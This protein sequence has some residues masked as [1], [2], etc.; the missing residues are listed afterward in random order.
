[1][2]K[3][4]A[5]TTLASLSLALFAS[6]ETVLS[7]MQEKEI[8]PNQEEAAKISMDQTNTIKPRTQNDIYNTEAIN[9][10]VQ[11]PL[12]AVKDVYNGLEYFYLQDGQGSFYISFEDLTDGQNYV[13]FVDSKTDK[14]ISVMESDFVFTSEFE[15]QFS[16]E[17]WIKEDNEVG[18]KLL[19]RMYTQM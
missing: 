16:S 3:K 14:L 4:F 18:R 7:P 2:F 13:G 10:V 5:I 8:F 19:N 9:G 1:M 12:R 11:M 15:E 6:P 17:E